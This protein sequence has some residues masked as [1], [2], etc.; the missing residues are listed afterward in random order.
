M[1]VLVLRIAGNLI[2]AILMWNK[3]Q[4]LLRKKSIEL[5]ELRK[6]KSK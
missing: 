1:I 2:Q 3:K 6:A 5:N 4:L